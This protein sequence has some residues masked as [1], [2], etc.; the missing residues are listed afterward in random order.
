VIRTIR[1]VYS[2][3]EHEKEEKWLNE[4]SAAGFQLRGVGFCTY[5]FEEG[6]PGEYVYR[7]EMLENWPTNYKSV[8][9]IRF[10]EETGVE[11]IGSVMRWVY[12]RKRTEGGPFD[13]YS[14]V[15]SRIAHYNRMLVLLGALIPVNMI[16]TFNMLSSWFRSGE[17]SALLIAMLC[18]ALWLLLGYGLIRILMKKSRLKKEKILCE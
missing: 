1:K 13:I 18:S 3:W 9:Y 12:F 14:D 4:M 10:L 8:T 15:S 2:L 16:N 7:L 17:L 11:Y 5:H 6:T